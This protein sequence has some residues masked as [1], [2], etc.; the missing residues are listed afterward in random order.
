M[1]QRNPAIT[2]TVLLTLGVIVGVAAC[3]PRQLS[4]VGSPVEDPDSLVAAVLSGTTP[5][6]P[7]QATFTWR[8]DEAGSVLQGRGV[9]RYVAPDRMRLDLFGP[10]GETYLIAALVG[11]EFRLPATAGGGFQLPSPT[12][13]WAALGVVAPPAS[14]TLASASADDGAAQL[15]YRDAGGGS[16]TFNVDLVPG[17]RLRRVERSG[18]S[19]VQEIVEVWHSAELQPAR[20]RHLDRASFRELILETE[21]IRKVASFPESTWRPDG[22][23][24]RP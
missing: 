9:V 6:S 12:L 19:G 1:S 22:T 7:R 23:G 18:G 5:G 11:E 3:A 14:S 2:A 20:T 21:S 4:P 8:M 15:V 10:R 17:P 24:D 13:L 16:F